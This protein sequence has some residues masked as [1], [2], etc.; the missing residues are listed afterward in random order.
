MAKTNKLPVV[1][2]QGTWSVD[3]NRIPSFGGAVLVI[4]DGK[5][6]QP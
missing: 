3:A 4:K 5:W 1:V 2:G 6:V